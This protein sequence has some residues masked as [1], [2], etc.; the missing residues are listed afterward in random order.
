MQKTR[1]ISLIALVLI[2]LVA[3]TPQEEQPTEVPTAVEA[4]VIRLTVSGSGSVTPILSAIAEEFEAVNPNYVLD[5]LAGSGTGGG[6]RGTVDGTLD[7]AAMSRPASED[8]AEQGIEF[9][10]FGTSST[11]V[12]THPNV[13][14]SEVSSEQLT[15]IFSGTITNWSELGGS[16]LDIIIYVRDPEEGNTRDIRE[17]F[18]GEDDFIESAQVLT[19]QTD[20]QNLLASV[21]GAIGYGTWATAL[22]NDAQVSYLSVDGI[23]I[24]DVPDSLV[25][26]LG[27]GYLTERTEDVQALIDWLLSEDGQTALEATGVVAIVSE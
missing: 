20:M 6:V 24:S 21:E 7:L 15:D 3:C 26:I 23:E 5:V 14:V 11:A 8:E 19:S 16:D 12:M 17:E 18:I 25:T 27:I 13:G 10:Q 2:I 9:V 22:A 4:N 1:Y